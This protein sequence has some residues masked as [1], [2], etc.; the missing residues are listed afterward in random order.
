LPVFLHLILLLA[1][2]LAVFYGSSALWKMRFNVLTADIAG[3]S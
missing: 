1:A 3:M 2:F